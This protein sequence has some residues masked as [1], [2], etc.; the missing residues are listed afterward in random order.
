MIYLCLLEEI[1][2][3]DGLQIH[4]YNAIGNIHIIILTKDGLIKSLQSAVEKLQIRV[5][6]AVSKTFIFA[7]IDV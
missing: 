5:R 7:S 4:L 3:L 6:A 2:T 1:E